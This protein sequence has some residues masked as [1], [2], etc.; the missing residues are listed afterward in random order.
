MNRYVKTNAKIIMIVPMEN[1]AT[2]MVNVKQAV[3]EPIIVHQAPNV[4]I[5]A[6]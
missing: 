3:L 4:S 1:S 5:T 2:H 6:V